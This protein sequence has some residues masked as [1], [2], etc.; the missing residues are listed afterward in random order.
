ANQSPR[1]APSGFRQGPD[2]PAVS[3]AAALRL[4]LDAVLPPRCVSC[5]EIVAE[6][7]ILCSTC[8]Q[9]ITFITP[10]FCRRCGLP[11]PYE[12]DGICAAC[13]A[14]PPHYD[15]ARAVFRYDD[16]SRD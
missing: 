14:A 2:R 1:R 10:P 3:P 6:A 7:G 13:A 16:A 5:G 8:W 12:A 4:A 9:G 11:F 15:R